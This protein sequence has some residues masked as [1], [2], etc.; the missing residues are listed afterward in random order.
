MLQMVCVLVCDYD[1]DGDDDDEKNEE[2]MCVYSIE[3]IIIHNK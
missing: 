2:R 3:P 1:D